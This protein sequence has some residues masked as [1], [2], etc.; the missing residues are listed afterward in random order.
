MANRSVGTKL[1]IGANFIADLTE[2]GGLEL[3]AD[4]IDT[5]TLDST[6]GYREFIGGFKDGGE[7][8]LSGFFKPSDAGQAA[9]YAAFM[10]GTTD[11]YQILFP[12]DLGASWDFKGVITGF[13]TGAALED[14]I[15]FE[16]TVKVSG[17]PSL[18]L[19][20]SA[21]LTAL[22]VATAT[23][24]PAF[25]GGTY[26]YTATTTGTSM[27]V[28]ATLTGMT[29]DVYVDDVLHASKVASG[30]ASPAIAISGVGATKKITVIYNENGKSA[31]MYEVIVHKTA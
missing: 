13:T 28:T 10:A 23:L 3:S 30:A 1:K 20:A 7:V 2:I 31:K 25:T 21:N 8:S 4:T 11:T 15:S 27:T 29:C 19:T 17:Q 14:A 16:A 24:A 22:A 5:T 26:N 9:V 12:S 18:G 6:G